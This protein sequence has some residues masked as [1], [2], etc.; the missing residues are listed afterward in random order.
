MFGYIKI[1]KPELRIKEWEM[2]KAVYCSLCRKLGKE[3][4]LLARF[5][6]SYDFTFLA[7]L[8]MSLN[9]DCPE[10]ERK[11]CAFNPLKKCS[12][13]KSADDT[14]D[15]VSAG[16][17]QL[18]YY[19]MLDNISDEKGIKR[20]GY[21][22]IFPL[23]KKARKKSLKKY[24]ELDKIFADYIFSQ[25]NAEKSLE[26]N[27]DMA[28]EPTALMLSKLFCLCGSQKD[29]RALS[30]LGYCMGRFI[31]IL[32]AAVDFSEDIKKGRYNPYTE[33]SLSN[34]SAQLQLCINEAELAFELIDFKKM[35]NILGNIV[36]LGLEDTYKK[37]ICK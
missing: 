35:K 30:R 23:F 11:A 10:I 18:L 25:E 20:L 26:R 19:K 7:C 24:A 15:F 16:A 36:Y 13:C 12:Y 29:E 1:Y 2:Y 8:K 22:I 4:G 21:K 37:E 9:A 17:M 5:T 32:D 28:A 3:Y 27:I 6:L 34:A 31:Y 33:E 14:L